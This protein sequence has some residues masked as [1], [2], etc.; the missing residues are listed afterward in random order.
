MVTQD[1]LDGSDG[2]F[3]ENSQQFMEDMKKINEM[4]VYSWGWGSYLHSPH[5]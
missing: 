3:V 2:L 5:C 1:S 4:V